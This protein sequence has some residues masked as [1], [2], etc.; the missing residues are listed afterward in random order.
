M[1]GHD[2]LIRM[3]VGGMAPEVI[4]INDYPCKTDWFVHG[5]YCTVSVYEDPIRTLDL[6]FVVGLK[7]IISTDNENRAK[8]LLDACIQ[9]N[10]HMVVSVVVEP[11]KLPWAQ[12]G[13]AKAWQ[14]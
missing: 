5:D 2:D 9:A 7:V 12:K 1:K 6:R 13:W 3:R 14:R 10:A 8:D 11:G 4:F